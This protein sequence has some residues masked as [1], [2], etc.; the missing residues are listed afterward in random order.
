M[1]YLPSASTA[2]F[3]LGGLLVGIGLGSRLHSTLAL[4]GSMVA[5]KLSKPVDPNDADAVVA[6]AVRVARAAAGSM[7]QAALSTV[8][9]DT[10]VATRVVLIT[11][12][13]HNKD[14][15]L[16]SVMFYTTSKSSKAAQLSADPLCNFT[17]HNRD[18]MACVTLFG[19]AKRLDRDEERKSLANWQSAKT[20][21]RDVVH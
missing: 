5:G 20:Q 8:S 12:L 11:P 13:E 3:G 18:T 16:V 2:A 9:P 19:R 7:P 17:F 4:L 21:T 1:D 14:D 6:R 15:S 10:G